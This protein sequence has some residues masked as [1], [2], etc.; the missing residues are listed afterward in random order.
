MIVTNMEHYRKEIE[1]LNYDFT[2]INGVV[3]QCSLKV[4]AKCDFKEGP[5]TLKVVEW[6]MSE[7][8]PESTLMLTL[9]EKHFVEFIE[10]G[11][12]ARDKGGYL[13][14]YIEKPAKE[15]SWWI[16]DCKHMAIVDKTLFPFITWDD[17]PIA[18]E[19]L[20]KLKVAE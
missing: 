4:C 7:Y 5:C 16:S 11:F 9:R 1:A 19:D 18:V 8:K 2:L 6:L 10:K 14:W 15:N 12:I 3:S 20:R 17:E 13:Y